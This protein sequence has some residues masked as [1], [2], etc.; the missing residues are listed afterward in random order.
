MTTHPRGRG[1]NDRKLRADRVQIDLV[2]LDQPLEL[3]VDQFQAAGNLLL[4]AGPALL[5]LTELMFRR[6]F[7]RSRLFQRPVQSEQGI[8]EAGFRSSWNVG[9]AVFMMGHFIS[10]RMLSRAGPGKIL[11]LVKEEIDIAA[12]GA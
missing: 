11:P 8:A 4:P 2:D 6:L 1:G 9:R 3:F 12:P 5:P 10:R 7:R